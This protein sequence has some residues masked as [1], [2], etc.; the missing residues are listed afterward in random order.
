M[1]DAPDSKSGLR[2][3]VSVQVRPPALLQ[4]KDLRRFVVRPFLL[5][6]VKPP[7]IAIT[8]FSRSRIHEVSRSGYQKRPGFFLASR[9]YP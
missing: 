1:A 9:L 6:N 2:K 8:F 4:D 3:R 7:Q 5:P